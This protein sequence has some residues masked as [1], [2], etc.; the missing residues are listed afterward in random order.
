[1]DGSDWSNA[2]RYHNFDTRPDTEFKVVGLLT[3][4]NQNIRDCLGCMCCSGVISFFLVPNK[5]QFTVECGNVEFPVLQGRCSD[6]K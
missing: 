6:C 4:V 3:G 2:L 5:F 1:L